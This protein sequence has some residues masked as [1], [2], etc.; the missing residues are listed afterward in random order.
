MAILTP[1]ATRRTRRFAEQRWLLDAVIQTVGLEWDQGRIGYAMGPCGFPARP[2]FE[3]VSNR[4]E[5][6]DDIAREFAAVGLA[7][8][9][10][11]EDARLAGH[12]VSEREHSFIASVLFSQAQWPIFENTEENHRLE[13]LKN[14]A[15]AAYARTA[16][17]PVRQVEL[18]WG[19]RSLPGWLHL[20]PGAGADQP[21]GCV[22]SIG[23][24]DSAKEML[25]GLY[26]DPILERGLAVLALDGPG[27]ASCTLRE[28]WVR[29]GDFPIATA[30]ALDWLEGQP[31]IDQSRIAVRGISMG[32]MWATQA[33]AHNDR[34][35]A[36]AVVYLCQERGGPAIFGEASPTFKAR[37]M[38]MAG[39]D[40]E[41]E[42]D[43][44]ASDLITV[45]GLGK[46]VH[47]PYLAIGGED[48]EL[49]AL[50]STF[51]LLDDVSAP[52]E[53]MLLQGER[54][55]LHKTPSSASV[56]ELTYIADWFA[57]CLAGR[58]PE[59]TLTLVGQDGRI[60]RTPWSDRPP[61]RHGLP[62]VVLGDE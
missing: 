57:D 53:L 16:D 14:A 46:L 26:G 42:F 10:R 19:E 25:V 13:S 52:K 18:P 9:R 22:I 45:E 54:H 49:T 56:N 2:D 37:F 29:P 27:Q 8:L 5:K 12:E 23:G 7:R 62:E 40:D 44:A 58:I 17:H 39:Y 38:Y 47:C 61:Y 28:I 43:A 34:I 41:N 60:R 31:E 4:V 20:P 32:S 1:H 35:K 48:D 30:A 11:A 3:R 51:A 36:C 24:M 6:F 15:Y 59:S 55:T 50:E 33:A 21:V